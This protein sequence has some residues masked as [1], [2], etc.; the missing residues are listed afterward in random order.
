MC[1]SLCVQR[2]LD[3]RTV[4]VPV[5]EVVSPGYVKVVPGEGMPLSKSP[6]R[7]GDLRIKFN[8]VFPSTLTR[9]QK[10]QLK[11]VL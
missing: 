5:A 10:D 6:S 4:R 7:R 2:T 3:G 9:A 8:V 11:T 1:V